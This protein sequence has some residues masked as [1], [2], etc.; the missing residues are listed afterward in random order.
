MELNLRV[1]S[2]AHATGHWWLAIW[3][4]DLIVI[5]IIPKHDKVERP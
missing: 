2:G 3:L 4:V 5:I 1:D